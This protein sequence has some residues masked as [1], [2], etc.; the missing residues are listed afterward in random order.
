MGDIHALSEDLVLKIAAG[1]VIEK[2]ANV[3]KELLENALDA[4]AT[5][6]TLI[7]D[8]LDI[9]IRDNGKGMI[10]EDLEVCFIRH[11]T[12]KIKTSD[13][14]F[15][16]H[17]LGF[18]G[19][20]LASISAV[21]EMHII[22][23]KKDAF[24]HE[25]VVSGGIKKQFGPSSFQYDSGTEVI[26]KHLFFNT[27][28]RRDFLKTTAT[29]V[30]HIIDVVTHYVFVN[31]EVS[32]KVIRDG[33]IVL[34][35]PKG[36]LREKY[37]NVFGKDAK[38]MVPVSF[39]EQHVTVTGLIS[40]PQIRK[41]S[42]QQQIL[43]VNGRLVVSKTFYASV[44][45]AY[46]GLINKGE[47]P[48][49]VLSVH[50]DA[51]EIDVNIHPTKQEIK[52]KDDSLF[53]RIIYH[54]VRETLK[55]Q[56]LTQEFIATDFQKKIREDLGQ[57]S[58]SRG[59]ENSEGVFAPSN[60]QDV[61]ESI[62]KGSKSEEYGYGVISNDKDRSVDEETLQNRPSLDVQQ[63]FEANVHDQMLL[64]DESK[65]ISQDHFQYLQDNA[66]S[67]RIIGIFNKE[68]AI[69]EKFGT[70]PEMV[71][72]DFHAAAEIVNYEKFSRQYEDMS[73][74]KQALL[75]PY[76]ATVSTSEML[77]FEEHKDAFSQMGFD[78]EAFGSD[79]LLIRATPLLFQKTCSPE[80]V[81]D[82]LVE[83][84]K[85]SSTHFEDKKDAI[86]TRMACKASEKAGDTLTFPQIRKILENLFALQHAKYNC[87]HGRPTLVSFSKHELER[88]FK[89]IM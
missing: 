29:E 83:L 17:S 61:N 19:E 32:F 56:D 72:V 31:P 62:A 35:T 78:I 76:Q 74:Q 36:S 12:S 50:I 49:L 52:F 48:A 59:S 86:I 71:I 87:P 25:L 5:E 6:I 51:K 65:V 34:H 9:T 22:S 13:D 40:K 23:K 57:E 37:Y 4:N 75:T 70:S 58:E 28:V 89:R 21:S 88:M 60:I 67:F 20:A 46:K 82:I 42:R 10:P 2:P 66:I 8:G 80:V 77:L 15:N 68:F 63:Y 73:V 44:T 3:V 69:V 33:D 81:Y 18:R 85:G 53:Y 24:A 43:F 7:L 45:H 26:V 79:E 16:I 64:S 14:L 54:A 38:F 30:R 55:S 41:K 27:P 84:A 39:N 47:Y 11:T 1:E